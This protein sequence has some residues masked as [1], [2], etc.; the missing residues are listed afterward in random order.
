MEQLITLRS[1]IIQSLLETTKSMRV[2]RMFLYMS[3]KAGHYWFDMIDTS[4]GG[5]YKLYL[6]K[7]QAEA[8]RNDIYTTTPA[9]PD[10]NC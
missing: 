6:V 5:T 1:D 2:K 4:N 9:V 7:L 8:N 3:E 10:G